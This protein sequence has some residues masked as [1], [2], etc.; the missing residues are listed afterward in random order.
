MKDYLTESIIPFVTAMFIFCIANTFGALFQSL[1]EICYQSIMDSGLIFV[2]PPDIDDMI[3]KSSL[4]DLFLSSFSYLQL[5]VQTAQ[6]LS[7]APSEGIFKFLQL[8]TQILSFFNIGLS[9]L[10]KKYKMMAL[11]FGTFIIVAYAQAIS[12][13]AQYTVTVI[14]Q[15]LSAIPVFLF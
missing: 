10:V 15:W 11:F 3:L 13:F 14:S 6:M 1:A 9:L 12:F 5:I 7:A 2:P 8:F 4:F